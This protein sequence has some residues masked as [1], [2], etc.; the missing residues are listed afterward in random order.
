MAKFQFK[1]DVLLEARKRNEDH[2]RCDVASLER[3]RQGLEDSLR[4]RQEHIGASRR[5]VRDRLVGRIESSAV[6]MQANASLALM[7]DAQRTVLELAG[8]H[9]RL[10]EA[11]RILTDA[12]VKRRAIEL[13]RDRRFQEWRRHHVRREQAAQDE[14][15]I[16]NAARTRLEDAL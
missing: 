14:L 11:R 15:A 12:S 16:I 8:L 3:K 13:L 1:L 9:R 4:L 5:S 6:R 10:Q 7:R 2:C